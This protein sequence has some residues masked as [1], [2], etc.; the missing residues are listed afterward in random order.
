METVRGA[1]LKN[2]EYVLQNENL[3]I[4]TLIATHKNQVELQQLYYWLNAVEQQTNPSP[5]I[6]AK[7]GMQIIN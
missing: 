4:K 6:P 2:E 3:P 5:I 1:M 7:K